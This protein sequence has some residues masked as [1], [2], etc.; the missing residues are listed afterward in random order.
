MPS[1]NESDEETKEDEN[2]TDLEKIE[3][4]GTA[5]AR[6]SKVDIS[7]DA[8]GA[9]GDKKES[10]AKEEEHVAME[11]VTLSAVKKTESA[12]ADPNDPQEIL[13]A[14]EKE[15]AELKHL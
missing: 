12:A 7:A 5:A 13:K 4:A 8:F 11:K 6:T 14:L 3:K 9:N 10:E 2:L 15:I 1:I